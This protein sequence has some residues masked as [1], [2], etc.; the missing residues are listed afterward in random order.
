MRRRKSQQNPRVSHLAFYPSLSSSQAAEEKQKNWYWKGLERFINTGESLADYSGLS[1]AWPTFWPT[2]IEGQDPNT[3]EKMQIVLNWHANAHPLFLFYRNVLRSV[4][5]RTLASTNGTFINLLFGLNLPLEQIESCF[6][7]YSAKG[8]P[9]SFYPE[10]G[11][12]VIR[13]V[14]NSDFQRAIWLLFC[15]RWRAKIC[16]ACSL[17]FIAEKSAQ[18]YCSLSCGNRAHQSN[19]LRWWRE[20]GAKRRTDRKQAR[21]LPKGIDD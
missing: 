15:E 5:I 6:P 8:A 14:S 13:F 9:T 20:K 16:P 1:K 2:T 3:A 7:G 12:G 19:S 17:Y 18:T 10:W 21:R 4:W 11:A